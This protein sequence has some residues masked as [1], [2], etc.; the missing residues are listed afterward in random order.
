M[1][2]DEALQAFTVLQVR[3]VTVDLYQLCS[4]PDFPWYLAIQ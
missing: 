3:R 2:L 1:R 4:N